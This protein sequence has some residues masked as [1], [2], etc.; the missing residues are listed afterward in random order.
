MSRDSLEA[1]ISQSLDYLKRL[2]PT[3]SFRFGQDIFTASHLVDSLTTFGA[4]IAQSWGADKMKRAVAASFWVYKSVGR[5]GKGDV[6]F[7]GYY[8]PALRAS[9]TFSRD[10]PWPVYRRPDDLV[11]VDLALFDPAFAGKRIMGRHVGQ[12]LVP[13]FTRK[14]IDSLG[15][16]R[17]KG[18]ELFWVAD[19]IDIFFLQIQGSGKAV[20]RD[21]AIR[22]VSYDCSNGRAYRSI[23]KLLIENGKISQEDMSLQQIRLYLRSHPDEIETTLNHN[24]SYV[25]FRFVDEGPVGA[26]G[27]PLTP[28]R[29]IATDLRLFPRAAP[30]FI[31]TEKPLMDDDG[32]LDSWVPC[33]RF[34]VNQDTGGAI[35]GPGRVDIFWGAGPYAELSAGHMKQNGT[36]YFLV[37][38][39]SVKKE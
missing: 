16:L 25:F 4:I 39:T 1:A 29:S 7:T 13:Y 26:I 38:K 30:A 10:F 19:P 35:R 5:Q 3:T 6:L 8:E 33:S 2:D 23:G 21:G 24:D 14:E 28:G 18:Y 11:A 34:V 32:L 37:K 36:L 20:F 15:R 9:R 31:Q 27:V 22:Q 12:S 17:N